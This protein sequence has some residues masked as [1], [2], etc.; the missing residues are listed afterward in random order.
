MVPGVKQILL[1]TIIKAVDM[2]LPIDQGFSIKETQP[3]INK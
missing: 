3:V 2:V 1:C